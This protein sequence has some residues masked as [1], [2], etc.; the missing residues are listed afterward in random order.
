MDGS[1]AGV[2]D[3][4]VSN[5]Q[6]TSKFAGNLAYKYLRMALYHIRAWVKA[7]PQEAPTLRGFS[8]C[9]ALPRHRSS[10]PGFRPVGRVAVGMPVTRHPPHRSVHALLTH[11]AL[12]SDAWRQT[13]P[14]DMDAVP[15]AWGENGLLKSRYA[16][17]S[18]GFFDCAAVA[19]PTI[20]G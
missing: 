7:V 17:T 4:E 2:H 11:T 14:K 15:S 6:F 16:P 18:G 10:S 19:W 5:S 13:A 20:A 9:L 8:P 12:I 1:S 3:T